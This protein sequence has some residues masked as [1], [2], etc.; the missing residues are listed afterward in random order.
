M[1]KKLTRINYSSRGYWEGLAAIKNLS[2]S[3]RVSEDD[4]RDWLEKQAIWQ[5]YLPPTSR[6][7]I[8]MYVFPI[9]HIKLIYYTYHTIKSEVRHIR[10]R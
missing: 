6:D 5:I 7:K 4:A 3:D 1:S 8:L 9:T 2:K 10:T